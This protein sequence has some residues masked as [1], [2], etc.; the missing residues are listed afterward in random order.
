MPKLTRRTVVTGVLEDTNGVDPGSGYTVVLTNDGTEISP[1]ATFNQ[2]SILRSTF[3]PAGGVVGQKGWNFTL[4]VEL[5]GGG[6][7]SNS[8]VVPEIDWLLQSCSLSR[9]DGL[10]LPYATITGNFQ[11]GELLKSGTDTIGT[12]IYVGE[13][14]VFIRDAKE[15]TLNTSDTITGATSSASF[16]LSSSPIDTYVYKPIT[17]RTLSK[18]ATVLF[19]KDGIKHVSNNVRG[20]VSFDLNVGTF[21]VCNFSLQGVYNQPTDSPNPSASYS[22]VIPAPVIN[23]GLGIGSWDMSTTATT[24]LQIALNNTLTKRLDMNSTDGV[25]SI[26]VTGRDTNGSINPEVAKISEYNPWTNWTSG[27]TELI[28]ATVGSE[29]GERCLFLVPKAQYQN[30][31]YQDRD[32]MQAYNFPFSC[33]GGNESAGGTGGDDELYLIF[34]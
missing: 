30:F 24:Q 3:S 23:V 27:S 20:T 11:N 13:D 28:K 19:F 8:L 17:D 12:L 21:A 31:T 16:A 15:V 18:S 26:E 25:R 32:G 33:L 29:E 1:D 7:E 5:K 9:E 14:Y 2:R 4:P 6:V 10:A 34:Y 22:Q